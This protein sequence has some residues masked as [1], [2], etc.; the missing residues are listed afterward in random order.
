MATSWYCRL[1]GQWYVELGWLQSLLP[2]RHRFEPRLRLAFLISLFSVAR[3]SEDPTMAYRYADEL[4][5]LR[6]LCPD[7]LL[8]AG[9]LHFVALATADFAQAKRTW[10]QALE[11]VRTAVHSTEFD[12]KFGVCADR[13]FILGAVADNIAQHLIQ[14]GEFAEATALIQESLGA[15]QARGYQSGIAA[16]LANSGRLWLLQGNLARAYPLLQQAAT[17]TVISIHPTVLAEIMLFLALATLYQ[18]DAVEAR[19]LLLESLDI[20][21][22]VRDKRFLSRNCIY[23]AEVALWE[24]QIEETE[25]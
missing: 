24:D 12:S 19:R 22:S 15:C 18:N 3:S 4:Q 9:A 25:Q 16:C 8:H 21:T 7:N 10:L 17:M 23:L 14:H 13:L 11:K 20:W 5:E 1:H 2:H 6:A